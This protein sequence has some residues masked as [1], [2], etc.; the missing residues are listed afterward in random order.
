MM[1][2]ISGFFTRWLNSHTFKDAQVPTDPLSLKQPSRTLADSLDVRKKMTA[3]GCDKVR[4]EIIRTIEYVLKVSPMIMV[5]DV[6]NPLWIETLQLGFPD[7][8]K[9]DILEILDR[10][11]E[12]SEEQINGYLSGETVNESSYLEDLIKMMYPRGYY[13]R[14]P[15][16][17]EVSFKAESDHLKYLNQRYVTGYYL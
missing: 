1:S 8:T 2:K 6:Y 11:R 4:T 10:L 3:F 13:F 5:N 12:E 15:N 7:K 16:G 9:R 14:G 17:W